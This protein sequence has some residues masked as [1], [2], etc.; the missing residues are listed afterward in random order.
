MWS[1]KFTDG[2]LRHGGTSQ[3]AAHSGVPTLL[4]SPVELYVDESQLG[5]SSNLLMSGI[6]AIL[7]ML[8]SLNIIYTDEINV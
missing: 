5:L 2:S 7:I 3:L 1:E 6:P 8:S 4:L